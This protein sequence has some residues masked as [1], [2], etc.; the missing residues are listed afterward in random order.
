M[1]ANSYY[2]NV[3]QPLISHNAV[4]ANDWEARGNVFDTE[5]KIIVGADPNSQEAARRTLESFGSLV[6][7]AH[8]E[9][10][11]WVSLELVFSPL[12]KD[13]VGFYNSLPNRLLKPSAV[14]RSADERLP[15]D[16][17]GYLLVPHAAK[18][19][20]S[21]TPIPHSEPLS[22]AELQQRVGGRVEVY[23]A[24]F[25][26]GRADI[27]CN[28]IG[29]LIGLPINLLATAFVADHRA[30]LNT[31]LVGDVVIAFGKCCDLRRGA[32]TKRGAR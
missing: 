9:S 7:A 19:W 1:D 10:G 30:D 4:H 25:R 21:L 29:K 11:P 18:T 26:G 13:P 24:A 12:A 22:L 15:A 2:L 27:H 16:F 32:A 5:M 6:M 23:G 20:G 28:E 31:K 3:L 8:V 14:Y 17:S